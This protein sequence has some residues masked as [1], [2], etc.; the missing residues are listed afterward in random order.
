[1]DLLATTTKFKYVAKKAL[2]TLA[3]VLEQE[4][5]HNRASAEEDALT[6]S[7]NLQVL[8]LGAETRV[9]KARIIND[10]DLAQ[11]REEAELLAEQ[12]AAEHRATLE[13]HEQ[14]LEQVKATAV[15]QAV[16]A[17][18]ANPGQFIII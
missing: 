10:Q 3:R 11:A 18:K 7:T 13:V 17:V 9:Q 14:A 12:R 2:P 1:M 16:A 5:A 6:T 8:T 15:A 4:D